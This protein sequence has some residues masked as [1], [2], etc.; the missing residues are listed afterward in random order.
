MKLGAKTLEA[1]DRFSLHS[2]GQGCQG[3]IAFQT[4]AILATYRAR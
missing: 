3:A 2:T 1:S 4:Q